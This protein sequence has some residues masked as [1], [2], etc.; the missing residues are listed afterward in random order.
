[1]SYFT[2]A[3]K[4]DSAQFLVLEF[5]DQPGLNS[6]EIFYGNFFFADVIKSSGRPEEAIPLLGKTI[7]FLKSIPD[8]S[9]Y[10]SLVYGNIAECYF[11][12]MNYDSAAHY[13]AKSISL[14]P[15]TS[16][17]SGG[18]AVN[19]MI[20][21]YKEYVNKKFEIA[22]AY[23]E[24]AIK[25]YK[26]RGEYCELPLCYTKLARIYNSIGNVKQCEEY[27]NMSIRV[28]DSC[29]IESYTLLAK[30]TMFEIYQEN[31]NYEAALNQ[32]IEINALV[33]KMENDKLHQ[34]LGELKVK[35]ET[36]LI[37]QENETL[38]NLNLKNEEILAKQKIALIVAVSALAILSTLT[39]LLIRISRKRKRAEQELSVLNNQLEQQVADRTLHLTEANLE[40]R[41]N[42]DLLIYQNKQLVD[43]CNIITHNLRSPMRNITTLLDFIDNAKN[44]SEKQEILEKLRPVTRN[45]NQTFDELLESLKVRQ[46]LEIK[47][48]RLKFQDCLTRA[49]AG[50]GSEISS[51]GATITANFSKAPE[52]VYPPKYLHSIFHNLISNALKY[53]S[54]ERNPIITL[55][56][57]KSGDRI[58]FSIKDN[59]L[60]IDL[61]KNGAK[62]FML[63]KVFHQ[64]RDAKGF[65]LF[66]TKTQVEA[67]K[68]KI[69]VES[70]PGK[71]TTFIIE[72]A[73]QS[74]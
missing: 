16:L 61:E 31:K 28:S 20:L 64:H 21:G 7:S 50:L 73:E 56:S 2:Y 72:F 55:E 10:V 41:E 39:V 53:S 60:G 14:S 63:G 25:E 4:F 46:D 45:M 33:G 38:Q 43:F 54:P 70:E 29:G 48:E 58:I 18:H 6:Q 40:I 1:M 37:Q 15:Q 47:S 51:T 35:Y 5:L 66:I 65:G 59:G 27:V 36:Q 13:S 32:L 30:R 69:R 57:K 42:T 74:E 19:Y 62:L 22:A 24:K 67:M 71:G 26:S 9:G 44:E 11:S 23:Y 12:S 8:S 68:G 52:V 17:R 49:I 3:S 34:S